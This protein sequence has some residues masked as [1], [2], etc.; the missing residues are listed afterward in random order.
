MEVKMAK[1]IVDAI[2]NREQAAEQLVKDARRQAE[3]MIRNAGKEAELLKKEKIAEENAGTK[4]SIAAIEAQNRQE[5]EEALRRAEAE[6]QALRSFA[7]EKMPE[8]VEAV[9]QMMVQ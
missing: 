6:A 2:R 1:E 4:A 3:E 9:L 5:T 8:A 7:A